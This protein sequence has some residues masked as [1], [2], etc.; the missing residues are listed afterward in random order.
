MSIKRIGDVCV[1]FLTETG[2]FITPQ[3]IRKYQKNGLFSGSRNKDNDFREYSEEEQKDLRRALMLISIGIS[4]DDIA[5]D[6]KMVIDNRIDS[7]AYV[8]QELKKLRKQG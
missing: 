3:C 1:D 8:I 2:I 6:N 7:I 5:N 4:M